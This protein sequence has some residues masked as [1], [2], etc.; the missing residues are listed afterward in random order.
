MKALVPS[1]Y[2]ECCASAANGPDACW[3]AVLAELALALKE[4]LSACQQYGIS[5]SSEEKAACP[6][7]QLIVPIDAA[8]KDS[9]SMVKQGNLG[10]R[11]AAAQRNLDEAIQTWRQL[12]VA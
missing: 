9:E 7:Q 1:V 4:L 8:M 10:S 5:L 6:A 2:S 11:A 12:C 3:H